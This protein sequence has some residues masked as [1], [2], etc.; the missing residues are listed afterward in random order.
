MVV[1]PIPSAPARWAQEGEIEFDVG[2]ISNRLSRTVPQLCKVA[3]NIQKYHMEDCT[4][5]GGI[6]S[7]LRFRLAGAALLHTDA[8]P[9]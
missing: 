1:P 9:P 7:I 6:F 5:A 4:V 3:P 8:A 2:A